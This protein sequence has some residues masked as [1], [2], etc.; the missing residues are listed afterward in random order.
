[1]FSGKKF[2]APPPKSEGARTPYEFTYKHEP[3]VDIVRTALLL[4]LTFSTDFC[5]FLNFDVIV[6]LIKSFYLNQGQVK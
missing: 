6:P 5:V 3:L 1:M 4:L 2:T